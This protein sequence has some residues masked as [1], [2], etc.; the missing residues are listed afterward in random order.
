MWPW[1][2]FLFCFWGSFFFFFLQAEIFSKGNKYLW[3]GPAPGCSARGVE[4]VGS[5]L[6]LW[7]EQVLVLPP[8]RAQARGLWDGRGMG[9]KMRMGMKMGMKMGMAVLFPQDLG[10]TAWEGTWSVASL[11]ARQSRAGFC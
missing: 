7:E 3:P 1:F 11:R 10:T 5:G 4:A 8:P 2:L 9:M 6:L